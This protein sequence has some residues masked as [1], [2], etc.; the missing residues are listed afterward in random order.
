[1]YHSYFVSNGAKNMCAVYNGEL[2][3]L[4]FG[5]LSQNVCSARCVK[6]RNVFDFSWEFFGNFISCD[7]Y[8]VKRHTVIVILWNYYGVNIYGK[9]VTDVFHLETP[10]WPLYKTDISPT[11][12]KYNVYK[13]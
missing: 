4:H 2:S 9:N 6:H 11:L 12:F 5:S 3:V 10:R 7:A 8:I 1:M 13:A